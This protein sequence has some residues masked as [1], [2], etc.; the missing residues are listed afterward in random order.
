MRVGTRIRAVA[1]AS[2]GLFMIA[3]CG[4]SSGPSVKEGGTLTYI[5]DADAQTLNPFEAGDLP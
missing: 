3:A 2:V 4:G 1:L 5:I